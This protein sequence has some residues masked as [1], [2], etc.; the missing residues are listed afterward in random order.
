MENPYEECDDFASMYDEGE[1][2]ADDHEWTNVHSGPG[3]R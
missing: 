2:Y 3:A 1:D